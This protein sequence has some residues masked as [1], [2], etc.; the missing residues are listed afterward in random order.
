MADK[1]RYFNT[2][3]WSD[4]Y[5]MNQNP[6]VKLVFAYLFTNDAVNWCGIYKI[7]LKKMTSETGFKQDALS[8]M[9]DSLEKD[10]KIK[11]CRGWIGM[12]NFIKQ[13]KYHGNTLKAF[14]NDF[15]DI[16]NKGV[17]DE[18][19]SWVMQNNR[20]FLDL[21]KESQSLQDLRKPLKGFR[22]FPYSYSYFNSY[23]NLNS[24]SDFTSEPSGSPETAP[25]VH[26]SAADYIP[27]VPEIWSPG[28][29]GARGGKDILDIYQRL[30]DTF[31]YH[32]SDVYPGEKIMIR[33]EI[34][35]GVM[36]TLT[37]N[38]KRQYHD[39]NERLITTSNKI[40]LLMV[41]AQKKYKYQPWKFNPVELSKH[42][43]DLVDG[44]IKDDPREKRI[45]P[46][47]H[48]AAIDKK[49]KMLR[50]KGHGNHNVVQ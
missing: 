9:L 13:N 46:Q 44:C 1:N 32:F 28:Y 31:Y 8:T 43:D 35:I 42:W 20:Q 3:F 29:R 50:E 4:E 24:N 25:M 21:V 36:K 14:V 37:A 27:S 16:I 26:E 6:S 17:P 40:M 2:A 45:N 33:K 11:Y 19:L 5:I 22:D 47:A 38:I 34:Y 30:F 12:K 41:I 18:L 23:F 15:N 49:V 39:H 48:E 10:G 7:A